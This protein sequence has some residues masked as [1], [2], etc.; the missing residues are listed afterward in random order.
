MVGRRPAPELSIETAMNWELPANTRNDMSPISRGLKPAFWATTPNA[1]P[2][3][4][5]P[6]QMG[7]AALAPSLITVTLFFSWLFLSRFTARTFLSLL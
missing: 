1:R 4:K 7:H 3:G 2:M 6:R 5:Y